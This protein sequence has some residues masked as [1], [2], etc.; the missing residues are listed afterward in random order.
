MTLR[1]PHKAFEEYLSTHEGRYT[2]QKRIIVDEIFKIKDHFEIEDFIDRLR[3]D[4][5]KL[6]RATVYRTV[7]Q[8]L[9][10]GLIQKISTRNGKVFYERS[11]PDK[12]HDHIICNSCGKILEIKES[13]ITDYL[14]TYCEK[15]EFL[16]E[17]R[18]LH[19]Y[20]ECSKCRKK[21]GK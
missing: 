18:S 12:H 20:G 19:I 6:S 11:T 3:A 2:L 13:F 21:S 1:N 14:N 10:A 9:D 4:K 5:A 16:P 8:L 17:Y 15:I 7:K